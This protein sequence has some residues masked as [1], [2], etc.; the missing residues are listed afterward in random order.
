MQ[1]WIKEVARGQKGAKDLSY[2]ETIEVAEAIFSKSATDAQITAYLIGERIKTES[3]EELLAFI[4]KLQDYSRKFTVSEEIK[5]K[6]IDFA[7]PYNGRNSFAATIPVSL[8]LADYGI[9]AYL[10]ASDT[11]PPKFGTS[12]KEIMGEL[13]WHENLLNLEENKIIHL[14]PE[15]YCEPLKELR[16][17]REEIGVRTLLN[18]VEKL[19]NLAN[20]KSIML[21]AFHRTAINKLNDVFKQLDYDNVYIVQ[22]LEGSEDVPVHRNSFVFHWTKDNLQSFTVK[23]AD[24]GLLCKEFDKNQKLSAVDQAKI[25]KS[26]LS[27]ERVEE[28][29]YYYNQTIL[30]AG[31][32]YYLFGVA[33]SVEEGIEVAK[34]Q[35]DKGNIIELISS[36][37]ENAIKT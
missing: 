33:V 20:A 31:L 14:D 21:G 37:K 19:L 28:N 26:I 11:L 34:K 27:G 3:A 29:T 5:A 24:Y 32:R 36:W 16:R 22:G 9:P 10:A 30:N 8:L 15:A 17:I 13:G 12:I 25:I 7:G 6:M 1:Q 4:R 35:L 18:T 23:P 2:E